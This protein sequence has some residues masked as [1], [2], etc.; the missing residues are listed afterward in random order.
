MGIVKREFAC[1][2]RGGS[3]FFESFAV[4]LSCRMSGIAGLFLLVLR[5]YLILLTFFQ[6]FSMRGATVPSRSSSR[7][8]ASKK[9]LSEGNVR[10]IL[11]V[12]GSSPLSRE[13]YRTGWFPYAVERFSPV[14]CCRSCR[15][16]IFRCLAPFG[17]A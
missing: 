3:L 6:Y 17:P 4:F 16:D 11:F 5:K 10:S 15:T 1:L 7:F 2:S 12:S 8:F 9:N 13:R 14:S